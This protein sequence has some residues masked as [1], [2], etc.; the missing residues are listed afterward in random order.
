M[1]NQSFPEVTNLD[2]GIGTNDV[3]SGDSLG[4]VKQLIR[5]FELLHQCGAYNTLY[6][7][8]E[9]LGVIKTRQKSLNS[10]KRLNN[11]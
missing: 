10:L 8:G 1:V 6:V 4:F 9:Y 3:A 5:G 7:F 11:W 2:T